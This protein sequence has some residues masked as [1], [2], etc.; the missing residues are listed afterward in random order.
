MPTIYQLPI[1][2]PAM[3]GVFPNQKFAVYGDNLA[4]ITAAGYLNSVN[5]ESNPI[6]KTDILQVLYSFNPVTQSGTYGVF[7]VSISN[8]GVIT[9]VAAVNPGDVLLPVVSG[10]IA[11]FNGTTGQIQDSGIAASN[12]MKLNTANQ[13]SAAGSITANKV[14]GTEAANAVTASGMAGVITTSALTTA[15]GAS[16]VITWTNTL[17]TATSSVQITLAGGTNT[18]ENITLKVVPGAGTATLTI[19]NNT[20]ATALNGTILLAY[21]VI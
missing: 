6:S 13:L 15:G 16:Y 2:Q 3:V 5:L 18:T 1:Q 10:N 21:L 17:I 9:L 20:A 12:L 19:Y 11:S 4:T 14:N 8:S 7:T